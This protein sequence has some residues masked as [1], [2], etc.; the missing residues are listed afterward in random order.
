MAIASKVR[1]RVEEKSE[2]LRTK[3]KARAE[4]KAQNGNSKKTKQPIETATNSTAITSTSTRHPQVTTAS[5]PYT[6]LPL[7]WECRMTELGQYYYVDN[8]TRT[9]S[10]YPPWTTA[11]PET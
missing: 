7:G 5:I 10:W 4:K 9:T 11:I 8:N 3:R 1:A 2:E 6:Q